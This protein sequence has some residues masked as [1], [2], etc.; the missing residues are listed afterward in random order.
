[1]SANLDAAVAEVTGSRQLI[2]EQLD[3]GPVAG[4]EWAQ[5][6]TEVV[7]SGRRTGVTYG[8]VTAIEGTA[9]LPYAGVYRII[10]NVLTI[11]PRSQ[12]EQVSDSGDSGSLWLREST[13]TVVGLHF[14]GGNDPERALAMDI[15]PV[16][17]ALNVNIGV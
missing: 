11:E 8:V 9:K 4:A 13:M 7:K 14:A 5:I 10:Q 2:N 15:Q 16:L 6:G 1:M 3:L 12:G 17:D